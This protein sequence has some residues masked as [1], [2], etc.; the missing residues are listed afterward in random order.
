[1]IF[2]ADFTELQLPVIT[3]SKDK[4][5]SSAIFKISKTYN[6]TPEIKKATN[7]H[8]TDPAAFIYTQYIYYHPSPTPRNALK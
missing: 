8:I 4:A 2:A 3:D 1:M 7:Q 6:N 5:I